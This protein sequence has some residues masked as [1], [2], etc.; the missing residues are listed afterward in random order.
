V[1]EFYLHL[2]MTRARPTAGKISCATPMQSVQGH[3]LL[4]GAAISL[5]LKAAMIMTGPSAG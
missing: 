2:G 3:W 4:T 5:L 1:S